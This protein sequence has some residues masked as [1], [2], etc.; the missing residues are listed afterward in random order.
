MEL[1][2]VE[3]GVEY[4]RGVVE[5]ANIPTSS[6]V[7]E[8]NPWNIRVH[9]VGGMGVFGAAFW[10]IDGKSVTVRYGKEYTL[11]P[12]EALILYNEMPREYCS[13]VGCNGEVMYSEEGSYVIRLAAVHR[14]DDRWYADDYKEFTISVTGAPRKAVVQGI[15]TGILGMPVSGAIVSLNGIR[16]MT[17]SDGS[18][19]FEDVETGDYMLS[20]EHWLYDRYEEHISVKEPRTY[21]VDV[22]LSMKMMYKVLL[23]AAPVGAIGG[24]AYLR[25]K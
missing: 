7:G 1:V 22:G 17:R 9:N 4:A 6:R 20:V 13:R 23:A 2:R 8:W 12:G 3:A 15:V 19:R 18:Y 21:T 11:N 14:E 25:K 10:L 5:D 24:V 16:R